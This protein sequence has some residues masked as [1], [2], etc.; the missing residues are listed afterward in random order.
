MRFPCSNSML[1]PSHCRRS[2]SVVFL[3]WF[4]LLQGCATAPMEESRGAQTSTSAGAGLEL[5]GEPAI[6]VLLLGTFHFAD[7]GLDAYKPEVDFDPMDPNRQR[8]IEGVVD[9]LA[10]WGPAKIAIE[11]SASDQERLDARYQSMRSGE[12]ALTANE[13]DQ[14]GIRLATRLDHERVHAVDVRG[15]WYQPEVDI[16]A[17]VVDQGQ[18]E[19][20]DDGWNERFTALYRY[21]DQLKARHSLRE[22]LLFANEPQRLL[23]KH[24][25]YLVGWV[26]AGEGAEYPGIDGVSAWYNRNLRIFG[27]LQRIA[28]PGDRLLVL[29]GSG[30]VPVIRHAVEASPEFRLIEV[31]D[32][33]GSAACR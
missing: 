22:H 2:I 18:Q 32:V 29:I 19:R 3:L 21:E 12:R 26:K 9:C 14:I 28:R 27:N 8:E 30:H 33:I 1:R 20:V 13:I 15:R 7:A 17:Y 31:A 25:H 11:W 16:D 10:R 4:V 23:A 24:G 6:E 5:L